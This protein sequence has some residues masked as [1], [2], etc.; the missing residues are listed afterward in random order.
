MESVDETLSGNNTVEGAVVTV[1]INEELDPVGDAWLA[2]AVDDDLRIIS[3][4]VRTAADVM[5]AADNSLTA[6]EV[7]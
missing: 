3:L 2:L 1:D 4:A 5:L 6:D 7:V